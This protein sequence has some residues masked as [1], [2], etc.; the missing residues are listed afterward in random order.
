MHT[1]RI[2]LNSIALSLKQ[3]RELLELVFL[4]REDESY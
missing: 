2:S 3:I 4:V 1:K